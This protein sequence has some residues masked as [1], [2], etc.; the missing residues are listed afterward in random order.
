M[1][2]ETPERLDGENI[3]LRRETT[4]AVE[5]PDQMREAAN[6]VFGDVPSGDK[7]GVS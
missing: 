4:A 7:N 5:D 6:E 1:A 3:A 2:S